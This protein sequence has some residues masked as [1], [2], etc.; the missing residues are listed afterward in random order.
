MIVILGYDGL[1]YEYVKEFDLKGLMQTTFG[2]TNISEFSEPRTVVIWSSFLAGKNLE[3]QILSLGKEFW[4]F[5][6]KPEE[7]FFSKFEKWKAID[8][9]GFTYKY[10]KH[11]KEKELMKAFFEGNATVKEYDKIAFE[12][13]KENK[14]EFFEELEKGYE[15]IMGYFALADVI[16]HL[17]F[18]VKTKMK[19]IYK[20]LEEIAKKVSKNLEEK[21]KLLIISD[22]G[23]KAIGRYG[24][25]SDHGFFSINKKIALKKPK[26]T[27]FRKLIESWKP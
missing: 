24:D 7:T 9:P 19:L 10:E 4:K 26:V 5:K 23:M 13:H 8:V 18:G 2:K 6:L 25:H 11:K 27:Q 15:I 22:H 20:E 21:D 14:K 16:G 17:S 12:N 3:R 1:E